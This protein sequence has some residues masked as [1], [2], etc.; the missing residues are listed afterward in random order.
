MLAAFK[1]GFTV[2]I[3]AMF[4]Q[5]VGAVKR[6]QRDTAP[7]HTLLGACAM[8]FFKINPPAETV[9]EFFGPR[10]RCAYCGEP[11]DTIDHTTPRWFVAGN[12]DLISRYRLV[13]VSACMSCN[14]I[15]GMHVDRSWSERKLRIAKVLARKNRKVLKT[16]DWPE[17]E[18]RDLGYNLQTMIRNAAG[19]AGVIRQRL[20]YLNDTSWHPDVPQELQLHIATSGVTVPQCDVEAV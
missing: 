11:A 16:A 5:N 13:K 19:I 2:V 7:D 6:H 1:A 3:H 12:F 20:I 17:A 8:T 9:Y 18:I 4:R 10:W 14:Q 15:A